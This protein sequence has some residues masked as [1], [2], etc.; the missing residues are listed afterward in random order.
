MRKVIVD[1]RDLILARRLWE[2]ADGAGPSSAVVGIVGAGHVKGIQRYWDAAGTLEAAQR[3]DEFLQLPPGEGPPSMV[4]VAVTGAV[5]GWMAYR[6]PKAMAI[7]AGAVT[8]MTVPYVAFG[9][10][11]MRRVSALAEKVVA[12]ANTIEQGFDDG[13]MVEGFGGGGTGGEEWQ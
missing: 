2:T 11:A 10:T 5:L 7:F 9:V 8:V 1:E 12:A 3:A 6:R 4:G 13:G